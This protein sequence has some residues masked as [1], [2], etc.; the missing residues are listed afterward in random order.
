LCPAAG[1]AWLQLR[2]LLLFLLL[3]P[4]LLLGLRVQDWQHAWSL[5]AVHSIWSQAHRQN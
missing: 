2:L 5:Q 4:L 1:A 3:V